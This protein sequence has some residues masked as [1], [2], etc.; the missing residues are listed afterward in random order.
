MSTANV[1]SDLVSQLKEVQ[2]W[3]QQQANHWEQKREE[4]TRTIAQTQND[5]AQLRRR[6][7]ELEAQEV[8]LEAQ[9][10][11]REAEIV[12]RMREAISTGL[13]SASQTLHTRDLLL[14]N[15]ERY[16]RI[17]LKVYCKNPNFKKRLPSI[18][19]FKKPKNSYRNCLQVID[20]PFFSTTMP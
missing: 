11:K 18:D 6:L 19:S 17:V 14:Q 15:N 7:T 20:K 5:I 1:R 8:D 2:D 16:V 13:E 10:N 9:V 3:G 12:H 4:L